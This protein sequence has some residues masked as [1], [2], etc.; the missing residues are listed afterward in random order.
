[1]NA[2]DSGQPS[3]PADGPVGP[4]KIVDIDVGHVRN[5]VEPAARAS[6]A[7]RLVAQ[8]ELCR[9]EQCVEDIYCLAMNRVPSL[10]F[11]MNSAFARRFVSEGAPQDIRE[12]LERAIEY[13]IRTVREKPAHH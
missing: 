5:A 13:A 8:P 7:A 9:C 2:G 12:S 4:E 11:N 1:M 6:I 10:Y 3:S